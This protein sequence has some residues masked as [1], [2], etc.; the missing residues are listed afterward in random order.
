MFPVRED[1]LRA[2]G[3]DY[4]DA[5][6]RFDGNMELYERLAVKFLDDRHVESLLCMV[7]AGDIEA[8]YR[9]AHSL[10]GVAGNLSFSVLYRQASALSD[11]LCT[12]DLG[13]ARTLIPQ[14]LRAHDDVVSAL[15]SCR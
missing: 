5:R 12:G 7:E 1:I 2:H 9:E 10:K 3:I 15:E 8:A 14:L 11:A 13:R 6:D 4:A